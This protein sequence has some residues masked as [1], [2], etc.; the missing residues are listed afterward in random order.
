MA[1]CASYGIA[2]SAF[3]GW[4]ADDRDKAI[5]WLLRE[6]DR[7]RRCGTRGEEWNEDAGGD[8]KAYEARVHVCPGCQVKQSTEDQLRKD[9]WGAGTYVALV[10]ARR[11]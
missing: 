6:A 3:L 4:D 7:C 5:W 9:D 1:V 2:H 10:P 8:R 11:R